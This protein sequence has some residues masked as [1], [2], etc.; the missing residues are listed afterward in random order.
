[1]K[2]K[3]ILMG[4]MLFLVAF[5]LCSQPL[6][7]A[8]IP[9]YTTNNPDEDGFIRE[10]AGVY[11][12]FGNEIDVGIVV[13]GPPDSIGRGYVQWPTTAIPD[14]ATI[15]D[16]KISFK[17][18]TGGGIVEFK[19]IVAMPS[20][21]ADADLYADIGN[22]T[23]Y[24]TTGV[25][26][27]GITYTFDL[28]A[29]ACTDLQAL[30]ASNWFAVGFFN[31]T[32]PA[33]GVVIY[34][35]EAAGQPHPTLTVTYSYKGIYY[36][37]NAKWENATATTVNV[38]IVSPDEVSTVTVGTNTKIGFTVK[39]TAFIWTATGGYPRLIYPSISVGAFTIAQAQSTTVLFNIQFKDL[40]NVFSKGTGTLR[41]SKYI[42][43]SL[44]IITQLPVPDT[45]T[46][47]PAALI[48]NTPY[49]ATFYDAKN[50]T[51]PLGNYI[52]IVSTLTPTFLLSSTPF[53]ELAQ[54]V[55]VWLKAGASRVAPY[56]TITVTYINSLT[57]STTPWA[58]CS[59]RLSPYGPVQHSL[60]GAGE[61]IV[62]TWAGATAGKNYFVTLRVYNTFFGNMTKTFVLQG[63]P[64][65]PG[66]PIDLSGLGNW[67]GV[68][69]TSIIGLFGI[70][71]VAGLGT[72]YKP[73]SAAVMVVL[74]SALLAYEGWVPISY[75][76]LVI[77]FTFAIMMSINEGRG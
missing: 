64:S 47:N 37:F 48:P 41:I 50:A 61:N 74:I 75:A 76:V 27:N 46:S 57:T 5:S 40:A 38:T 2:P 4:A 21:A 19:P 25:L 77:G 53:G 24:A 32:V 67:G 10:T 70:L 13:I 8:M 45:V 73:G 71:V 68:A 16:V 56:T 30:L 20:T 54:F 3:L 18:Q 7:G 69:T 65:T 35:E 31:D 9:D 60:A 23:T 28:G 11:V 49:I 63:T 72:G 62:F 59:W 36:T 29:S 39:P 1:L 66:A 17:V 42:G 15:F 33:A 26:A 52:P 43:G 12:R 22:G 55:S 6:K 51:Y 14:N 58:N 34:A 44:S